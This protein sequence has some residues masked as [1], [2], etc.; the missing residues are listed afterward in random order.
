MKRSKKMVRKQRLVTNSDG[1]RLTRALAKEHLAR[2]KPSFS[3]VD[4]SPDLLTR[5]KQAVSEVTKTSSGL[6]TH[7]VEKLAK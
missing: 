4:A 6:P 7:A 5:L 2:S 3:G 1:L